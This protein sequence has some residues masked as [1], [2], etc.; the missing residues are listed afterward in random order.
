MIPNPYARA[1]AASEL[2]LSTLICDK[3]LRLLYEEN[4]HNPTPVAT[5]F[6]F[7]LALRPGR[8]LARL[9]EDTGTRERLGLRNNTGPPRKEPI[10]M[11]PNDPES[12]P[13]RH[14]SYQSPPLTLSRLGPSVG[15]PE[16]RLLDVGLGFIDEVKD[17][18]A[19]LG[20]LS[21]L[22]RQSSYR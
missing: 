5:L 10:Q 20:Q 17:Q 7:G 4:S 21:V 14:L 8:G 13:L 6:Y 9:M 11:I 3:R 15:S 22:D 12:P 2:C 18:C 19:A 1:T 16:L